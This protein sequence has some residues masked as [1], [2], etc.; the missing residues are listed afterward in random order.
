MSRNLCVDCEISI[1]RYKLTK[2]LQIHNGFDLMRGFQPLNAVFPS[3]W[4]RKVK[5]WTKSENLKIQDGGRLW[6]HLFDYCCHG[7]HHVVS[8]NWKYKWSLL[9][10]PNFKLIGWV[11]LKVEGGV[12]LTPPPSRLRVTIFSRRLLGLKRELESLNTLLYSTLLYSTLLYSSLLYST[13]LY[14]TLLYSTLLYPTLLYS[15]LLYSTLLHTL[16]ST[17]LHTLV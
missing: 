7:W 10:V 2:Y 15:T 9:Y 6:R 4:G 8:L 16:L 12:R 1:F 17:L 14:P 11:V 5:I 3:V 13:L